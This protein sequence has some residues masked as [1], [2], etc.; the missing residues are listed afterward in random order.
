MQNV[1]GN[2]DDQQSAGEAR[3]LYRVISARHARYSPAR[4]PSVY[5]NSYFTEGKR[6]RPNLYPPASMLG[7]VSLYTTEHGS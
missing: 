1:W 2:R 5:T 7:G 6:K 4:S 3:L